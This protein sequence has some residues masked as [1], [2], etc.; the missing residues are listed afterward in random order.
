MQISLVQDRNII[1]I[2]F[3]IN[4]MVVFR[5]ISPCFTVKYFFYFV[6]IF[7]SQDI[8]TSG[9]LY[10]LIPTTS[11]RLIDRIDLLPSLAAGSSSG[12]L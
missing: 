10:F 12:L 4:V 11:E 2:S 6:E 3:S 7:H 1:T 5:F 8:G 9:C